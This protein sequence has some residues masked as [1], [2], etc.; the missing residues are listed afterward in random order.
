MERSEQRRIAEAL[1][2]G[3][4]EPLAPGRVADLIPGGTPK[5]VRELVEELN[6]EY[7]EQRRAF[8]ISYVGG[9]YQIRT[10]PE[11]APYLQ[12]VQPT[13][14]LRLSRAALETLAIVA[15]RQPVTRA[16]VEQIRGVDAGAVTRSLLERKLVRIAG[17]REVAGRPLLYGT[18]RR[19]LEVF[20][21]ATLEDLPTLR[22]LKELS[23]DDES[24]P[25]TAPSEASTAEHSEASEAIESVAASEDAAGVAAE[26]P[27]PQV[28]DPA[29]DFFAVTEPPGKPH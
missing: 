20:G 13:R 8:E 16:E 18:S 15:Y 26:V 29:G 23:P 6:A 17:H 3:S 11:F 21:L 27:R 24:L 1:I 9:G 10:L 19:F 5:L 25:D 22:E 28:A 14:P 2:L 4:A 7:A 12:Q